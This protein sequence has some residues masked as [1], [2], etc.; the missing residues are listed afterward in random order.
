MY[1]DAKTDHFVK[2]VT[3]SLTKLY[4]LW[5]DTWQQKEYFISQ[6]TFIKWL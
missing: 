1:N 4:N 6:Q 5:G 2:L 3:N